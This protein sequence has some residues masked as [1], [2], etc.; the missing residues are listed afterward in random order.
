MSLFFLTFFLVYGGVHV[1]AFIRARQAFSFSTAAGIFCG[2]FLVFM[3]MAPVLVR[4]AERQ[5]LQATARVLAYLGYSWMGL[6]F[7]FFVASLSVDCYRL[8]LPLLRK[9]LDVDLSRFVPSARAAFAGPATFAL[10]AALYGYFEAL[11][12][13]T[14]R[15]VVA[16]PKVP[17]G[18]RITV[19]Q[20]SDVHVGLIVRK[21]RL[22]R[23]AA[24][25]RRAAPDLIVSTGDLVDGQ[26]DDIGLLA[27]QL[28]ELR[29]AQGMFAV[30]GNHEYY[31]GLGQALDFTQRAGFRVLRGEV[32]PVNDW[33]TVAGV[34]DH[35][36]G[37]GD[38]SGES[39]AEQ[40]LLESLPHDRVILLLKHR[41]IVADKGG[42]L[43]DLQL[44]GHVHKGQLFPFNLV[45]YLFYPVRTG[46]SRLP[47]GGSLYVSRGT[48]TWGPPLRFLAPPEVT[49]F[50]FVHR[51]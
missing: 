33:F 47:G 44:S 37:Q 30:T 1:Y 45:T 8:L 4:M 39:S 12:I 23:I 22:A 2:F 49:V 20:V 14:E 17:P 42:G 16:S 18:K 26:L 21:E 15:V 43:F 7:F 41:P 13:R 29:P 38:R 19:V 36:E 11:S 9:C 35:R 5:G 51:D 31:A 48:G 28:R 10:V 32:F 46:F 6:L 50:E 25:V 40:R 27:S 3:V 24:T 34:D